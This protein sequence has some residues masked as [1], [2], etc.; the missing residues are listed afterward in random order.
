M[1]KCLY[2]ENDLHKFQ[3][4]YKEERKSVGGYSLRTKPKP[5][6]KRVEHVNLWY[7]VD[8]ENPSGRG[9]IEGR[10]GWEEEVKPRREYKYNYWGGSHY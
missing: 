5:T 10:E 9:P 2:T 6:A 3:N 1:W 4:R 7:G 8:L